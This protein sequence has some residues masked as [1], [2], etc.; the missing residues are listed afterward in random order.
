MNK[1]RGR[2]EV[3]SFIGS[4][5]DHWWHASELTE[6]MSNQPSW[7]FPRLLRFRSE[8]PNIWPHSRRDIQQNRWMKKS[9]HRHPSY[10]KNIWL[11]QTIHT[12]LISLPF[13]KTRSL[14]WVLFSEQP[15]HCRLN[16]CSLRSLAR[17]GILQIIQHR[18]SYSSTD[19]G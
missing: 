15:I 9:R 17:I 11:A 5:V 10:V 14:V 12:L 19:F 16:S 7:P 13:H 2:R 3:C 8:T 1:T 6:R 4:L 18:M